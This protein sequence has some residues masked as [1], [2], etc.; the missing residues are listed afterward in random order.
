MGN[1]KFIAIA[2]VVVILV[3]VIFFIKILTIR[4]IVIVGNRN[5]TELQIRKA[6]GLKE[7]NSILYLK[8][9]FFYLF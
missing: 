4:N 5:L 7:G 3:A 1:K 6:I 2:G 8:C 9:I